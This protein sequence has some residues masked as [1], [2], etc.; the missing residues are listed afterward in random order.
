MT[1]SSSG[2]ATGDGYAAKG[3]PPELKGQVVNGRLHVSPEVVRFEYDGKIILLPLAGLILR[4]GGHNDEQLF[5]EHPQL[6]GWSIISSD[7]ALVHNTVLSSRP[8]FTIQLRRLHKA[9]TGI[10]RP[11]ILGVGLLALFF[12]LLLLLIL[13]K[14]RIVRVIVERIPLSWEEKLGDQVFQQVTAGGELVEES[15]WDPAIAEITGRLLPIV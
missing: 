13:Q 8:E 12:G 15:D 2:T 5:F 7:P 3:Y 14:D 6:A 1:Q 4:V 10:P 9:R 11:V